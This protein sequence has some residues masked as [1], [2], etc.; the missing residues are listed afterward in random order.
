MRSRE[1]RKLGKDRRTPAERK[2]TINL[3]KEEYNS[4]EK[5]GVLSK[6]LDRGGLGRVK[7]RKKK[8]RYHMLVLEKKRKE[9]FHMASAL[10]KA[11]SLKGRPFQDLQG[12]GKKNTWKTRM[13]RAQL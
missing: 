13:H 12:T 5:C 8:H 1:R 11:A 4:C 3:G 10:Q 2:K 9:G 7:F 6:S